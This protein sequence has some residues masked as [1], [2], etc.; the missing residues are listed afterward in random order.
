VTPSFS[1]VVNPA[2]STAV[3]MRTVT[4]PS[5][6]STELR[7]IPAS[8]KPE[9][10]PVPGILS[11]DSISQALLQSR[12]S[13]RI[14]LAFGQAIEVYDEGL[15]ASVARDHATFDP[16][17]D[18][19]PLIAFGAIDGI[20]PGRTAEQSIAFRDVIIR[21]S[22][23]HRKWFWDSLPEAVAQLKKIKFSY[24]DLI[25]VRGEDRKEGAEYASI[26]STWN[27]S[28]KSPSLCTRCWKD[29]MTS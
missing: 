28:P 24:P 10:K 11:N 5:S 19:D 1:S 27:K 3:T 23:A 22:T 16:L 6:A 25:V 26:C 8:S 7:N 17:R 20:L 12:R 15:S 29:C 2:P 4:S 14:F 18:E 9:V 13:G 21:W